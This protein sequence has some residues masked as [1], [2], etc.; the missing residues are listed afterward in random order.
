MTEIQLNCS[1]EVVIELY[2]KLVLMKYNYL[3]DY[4]FKRQQDAWLKTT[5]FIIIKSE[6]ML[7]SKKVRK[8]LF[9]YMI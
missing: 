2:K 6:E 8:L 4:D 3:I 5:H 1:Y 9:M 7:A